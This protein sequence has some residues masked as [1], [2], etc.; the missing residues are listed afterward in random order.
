MVGLEFTPPF[1]SVPSFI[2][3][4]GVGGVGL[5]FGSLIIFLLPFDFLIDRNRRSS[6]RQRTAS[7]RK[8]YRAGD[9]LS[10]DPRGMHRLIPGKK[11]E[12]V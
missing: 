2:I 12:E 6:Q 3:V 9:E 7:R 5:L 1:F 11:A 4:R 10:T 8:N